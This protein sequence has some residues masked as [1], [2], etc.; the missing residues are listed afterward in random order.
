MVFSLRRTIRC[1]L[2]K[3]FVARLV[4]LFDLYERPEERRRDVV[5][6]CL[7]DWLAVI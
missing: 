5:R 1:L 6:S 7:Y 4:T 3:V 2:R